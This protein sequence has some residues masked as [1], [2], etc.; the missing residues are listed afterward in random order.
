MRY[1]DSLRYSNQPGTRIIAIAHSGAKIY[2]VHIS[3]GVR[4][5]SSAHAQSLVYR[6]T[7][8][9]QSNDLASALYHALTEINACASQQRTFTE[10]MRRSS[11]DQLAAA[12]V[13]HRD[14]AELILLCWQG[15]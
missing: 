4:P 9:A 11:R 15:L 3:R 2:Q 1:I 14:V 8:H 6:I 13:L 10:N 5:L 12:V 7:T